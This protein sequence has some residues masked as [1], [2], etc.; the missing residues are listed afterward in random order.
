MYT[1]T[2]NTKFNSL[3]INFSEK[4][5]KAVL[6]ALKALKFRWNNAKKI[7]YGF[8][9]RAELEKAL[10]G[11]QLT[12]QRTEQAA[13]P[14]TEPNKELIKQYIDEVVA[15]IWE[16]KESWRDYYKKRI[17][18]VVEIQGKLIA[19]KKP[20]IETDFYFGESGY[21][22]NEKQMEAAEARKSEDFFINENLSQI[23][24]DKWLKKENYS[25]YIG[26]K[27]SRAPETTRIYEI[28]SVPF[29]DVYSGRFDTAGKLELSNDDINILV[30]AY[31]KQK[32]RF[33]KRLKTY[34]KRYGLS[35]VS[36][37]T[38]WADR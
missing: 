25:H 19:L 16:N 7:W 34:L 4:P 35:K 11:E 18:D 15:E 30:N 17:D 37:S 13:E 5:E 32:I 9:E 21:D 1:I 26:I 6:S 33:K 38:Y 28:Y 3:E 36:C 2:E 29:C 31:E 27:Y 23:D 8:C 12:E 24:G 10:N 20:G 14:T 22:Y